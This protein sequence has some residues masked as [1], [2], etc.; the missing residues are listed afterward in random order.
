MDNELSFLIFLIHSFEWGSIREPSL[1]SPPRRI[2]KG[3]PLSPFL[4]IPMVE[5]LGRSIAD[6]R[7]TNDLI[8]IRV[9]PTAN[10]QTH[11]QFVDDTMLMGYLSI[12]EA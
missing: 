3:D 5:G 10:K 12:Q 2:I 8:G 1:I 6:L 7:D 4:F 9:H 11:Q